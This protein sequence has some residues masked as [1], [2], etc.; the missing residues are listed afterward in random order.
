[1]SLCCHLCVRVGEGLISLN[2]HLCDGVAE[3]NS[4]LSRCEDLG[5]DSF[6]NSHLCVELGRG[7]YV[8][9]VTWARSGE[10]L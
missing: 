1:M 5:G 6:L 9:I 4:V 8:S 3:G 10:R 7:S 2:S